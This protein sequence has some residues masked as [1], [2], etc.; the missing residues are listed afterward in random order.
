MTR[1]YCDS[2]STNWPIMKYLS[3]CQVACG[4]EG[5]YIDGSP[6]TEVVGRIE[7]ETEN[8]ILLDDTAAAK[9]LMKLAHRIHKLEQNEGAPDRNEWLDER[10]TEHRQTFEQ[11]DD[12]PQL[13]DGWLP[14]SQL[15]HIVYRPD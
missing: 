2:F 10:L 3:R 9:P 5:G 6:P 15:Q 8:A 1:G 7:Q 14:K 12:I 4:G 13:A 11:R